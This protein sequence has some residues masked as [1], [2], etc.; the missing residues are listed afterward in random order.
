[1]K[2]YLITFRSI[3]F[4]Q[5]GEGALKRAGITCTLLRTPRAMEERGCGYCLTLRGGDAAAAL[6][7]LR[8]AGAPYRKVYLQEN[9][10]W[11][12]AAL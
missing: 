3:T 5:K 1:M 10:R 4:A 6:G 8:S 12:E 9:G 11:E 7:V 2:M